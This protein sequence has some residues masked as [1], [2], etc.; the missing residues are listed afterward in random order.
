[1]ATLAIPLDSVEDDLYSVGRCAVEENITDLPGT[2][3]SSLKVLK[4]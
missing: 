2:T 3:Q 4:A 1:M